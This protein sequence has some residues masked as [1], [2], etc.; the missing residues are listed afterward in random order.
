M[1]PESPEIT[2][3]LKAWGSGDA[4]ALDQLTPRGRGAQPN[5]VAE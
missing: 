5:A 3:L 1:P 2:E 4:E